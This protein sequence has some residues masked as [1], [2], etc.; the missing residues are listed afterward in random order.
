MAKSASVGLRLGSKFEDRSGVSLGLGASKAG[1]CLG[2]EEHREGGAS[3]R[4]VLQAK[5]GRGGSLVSHWA[6]QA[7]PLQ[8]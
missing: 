6:L 3:G 5:A 7:Q 8:V 1:L 2:C 4:E